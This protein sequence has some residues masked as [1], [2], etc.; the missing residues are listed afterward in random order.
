M[1]WTD[2]QPLRVAWVRIPDR[3]TRIHETEELLDVEAN[4]VP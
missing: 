3:M 2:S 4:R 1:A